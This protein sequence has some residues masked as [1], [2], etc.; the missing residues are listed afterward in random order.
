MPKRNRKSEE[1]IETLS[2]EKELRISKKS[3]SIIAVNVDEVE[4]LESPET[5]KKTDK[6]FYRVI[7]L[8][9]GLKALLISDLTKDANKN[10][11]T[12]R[13]VEGTASCSL[14]VGS[15]SSLDPRNLQGLAHL[16]GES[17]FLL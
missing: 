7:K 12:S 6:H 15:G 4:R 17:F 2:G 11:I 14:C 16:V 5:Y 8:K 3:K 1:N 9:N 13:D 10:I